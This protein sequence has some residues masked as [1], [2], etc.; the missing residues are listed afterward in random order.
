M[1]DSASGI[2]ENIA[3]KE[4]MQVMAYRFDGITQKLEGPGQ[5]EKLP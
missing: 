2:A 1:D 4:D 5:A 3:N